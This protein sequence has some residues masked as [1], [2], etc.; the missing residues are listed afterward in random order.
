MPVT[1]LHIGIPG[2]ISYYRPKKVDIA[3]AI[4]GSVI[5]D[6]DF[7]LFILLGT[8]VHGNL[9]SFLAATIVAIALAA[10]LRVLDRNM[11]TLKKWFGW[12]TN[13][14]MKSLLA[15]A[16][17]GTYSHITLDML[18]YR[19]MNPLFPI[20]GNPFYIAGMAM[21]IFIAVYIT[22]GATTTAFLILY[23]E[24]YAAE[25]GSA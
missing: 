24:K 3:S 14:S 1:P 20:K 2:L 12:E 18:I 25:K 16:L 11:R 5:I 17:I 21:P 19:E 8:P 23:G 15:G 6:M 22:A 9:H 10:I 4:I 13:S 7:L